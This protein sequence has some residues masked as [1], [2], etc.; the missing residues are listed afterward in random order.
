MKDSPNSQ[1]AHRE[2]AQ[3]TDKLNTSNEEYG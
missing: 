3:A 2:G 1:E